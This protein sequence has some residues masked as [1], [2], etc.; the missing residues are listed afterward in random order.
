MAPYKG[1][2][3]SEMFSLCLQSLKNVPNHY[4]EL[5]PPKEKI[6]RIVFGTFLGRLGPTGKKSEIKPPSVLKDSPSIV[7]VETIL[8]DSLDLIPSPS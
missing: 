7:K 6:L 8:K 5:N 4:P 1:G 3:I 2:L